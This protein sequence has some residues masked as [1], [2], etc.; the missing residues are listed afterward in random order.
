[1]LLP[2][3]L[4]DYAELEGEAQAEAYARQCGLLRDGEDRP[5]YTVMVSTLLDEGGGNRTEPSFVA[6]VDRLAAKYLRGVSFFFLRQGD[7]SAAGQ[8]VGF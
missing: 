4:D 1:M 6:S 8:P 5:C 2:L 7:F 3:V